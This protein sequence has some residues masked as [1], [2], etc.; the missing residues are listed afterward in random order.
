MQR[1]EFIKIVGGA[2]VAARTFPANAQQQPRIIILHSGFP[3]RTPIHL[4]LEALGKLGYAEADIDILG[5][6]GDPVRLKNLVDQIGAR[7]PAVII[8]I[9]SPAAIALKD[10][11]LKLPVVFAF[12]SDPVGIGLVENFSRPGGDFTGVTYGEAD[13]GGKKLE[14]LIDVIGELKRVAVLWSASL[15][16]N[17]AALESIQA[18]A[19][20]RRIE[21]FSRKLNGVDDVG[22]AFDEAKLAKVQAAI[23][24]TDNALFGH[25][26]LVAELAIAHGLPTIH[27][28]IAEVRDGG[29]MFYGPNDRE[30]YRRAAALVDRILR[31]A[32]PS[33]LP[34]ETPTKYDLVVNLK[35]AKALGLAIPESFLLRADEVIE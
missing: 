6:E 34:V 32:R 11:K 27:S 1:R 13:L 12:L 7:R 3:K 9:T 18:L 35:T 20:A 21:I 19:L 4:L 14:Q 24:M 25:R 8:A 31:G 17:T 22:P 16:G 26:K 2:I 28:F 10:A 23:F 33:E 30:N 5:G 15:P 29:L